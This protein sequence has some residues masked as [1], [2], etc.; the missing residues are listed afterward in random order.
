[1]SK[2]YYVM[3][4]YNPETD[5]FAIGSDMVRRYNPFVWDQEW[6][7]NEEQAL[8]YTPTEEELDKIIEVEARLRY[9]L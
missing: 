9:T 8:E 4:E 6:I 2:L 5:S 7:V 1:M 3:V